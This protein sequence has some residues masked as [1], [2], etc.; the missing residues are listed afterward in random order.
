MLC[1]VLGATVAP[2]AFSL[3]SD[4]F[5]GSLNLVLVRVVLPLGLF[6]RLEPNTQPFSRVI[7]LLRRQV[8]IPLFY[9]VAKN[10]EVDLQNKDLKEEILAL[11]QKL[12]KSSFPAS[13]RCITEVL[14]CFH[15]THNTQHTRHSC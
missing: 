6:D 10:M 15:T 7:T 5:I 1:V 12:G 3:E 13:E 8:L 11:C 4:L 9:V 14:M 2:L